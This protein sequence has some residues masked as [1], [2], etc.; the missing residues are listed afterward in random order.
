MVVVLFMVCI[1]C[2]TAFGNRKFELEGGC[3]GKAS[4]VEWLYFLNLGQAM[5]MMMMTMMMSMMM[6]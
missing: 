5:M 3:D 6:S 2:A 1:I 4:C